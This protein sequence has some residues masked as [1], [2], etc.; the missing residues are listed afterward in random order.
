MSIR[1]AWPRYH[2]VCTQRAQDSS[3]QEGRNTQRLVHL[4]RGVLERRYA[5]IIRGKVTE[6]GQ[7]I[8]KIIGEVV[9]LPGGF[10]VELDVDDMMSVLVSRFDH[11]NHIEGCS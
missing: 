2:K 9:A 4:A 11:A 7:V 8:F 1:P 10:V 6:S 5:V 3:H